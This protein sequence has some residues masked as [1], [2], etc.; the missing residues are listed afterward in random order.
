MPKFEADPKL[1]GLEQGFD[2]AMQHMVADQEPTPEE[3]KLLT[4]GIID[5]GEWAFSDQGLIAILDVLNQPNGPELWQVVPTIAAGMLQKAR[6]A[7]DQAA[8]G[9]TPGA[10][11]F[12]EGGM[13]SS[14]VDII[15]DIAEQEQVPGYDDPDQ[16]QA[17][18]MGVYK[19]VGEEILNTGDANSI[20]EA[21]SL[22]GD[23]ARTRPDGS[24]VPQEEI[25]QKPIAAAVQQ[26]LLGGA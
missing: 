8:G 15:F 20:A 24:M 17:S 21:S 6:P 16:Y 7:L 1:A 26:G 3:E 2:P 18:V 4:G 23:V 13:I 25:P 12:G 9:E 19:A 10:V 14:A 11:W 5:M 22:A